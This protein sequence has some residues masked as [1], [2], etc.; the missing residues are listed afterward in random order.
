MWGHA[1]KNATEARRSGSVLF[2]ISVDEDED[3]CQIVM[4]N[5]GLL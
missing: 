4:K 2:R 5:G 1:Q 3:Y